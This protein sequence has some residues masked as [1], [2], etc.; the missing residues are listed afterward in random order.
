MR[1]KNHGGRYSVAAPGE[2]EKSF[3]DIG[4][5]I[6]LATTYAQRAVEA[7]TVYVRDFDGK[8][9]AR[10]ERLKDGRIKV[11]RVLTSL[12]RTTKGGL[13]RVEREVAS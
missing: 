11:F 5:A 12:E 3:P 1:Q 2:K 13:T 9:V 6:S 8:H 10:A 4:P 7:L